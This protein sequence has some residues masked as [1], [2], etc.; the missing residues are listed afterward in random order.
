MKPRMSMPRIASECA[1]ASVSS[2]ATL[3][4]PA[5]PRPPIAT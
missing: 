4:P 5:L 2:L 3:I 1:L